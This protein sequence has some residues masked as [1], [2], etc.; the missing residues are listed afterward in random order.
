MT[1]PVGTISP[2]SAALA[3]AMQF[4]FL[5]DVQPVGTLFNPGGKGDAR[6]SATYAEATRLLGEAAAQPF[7]GAKRPSVVLGN[8]APVVDQELVDR[9]MTVAFAA[10]RES[11]SAAYK[12]GAQAAMLFMAGGALIV[13]DLYTPGSAERD[14]F[15]AGMDEG[16]EI[17]RSQ[18][19]K[20]AA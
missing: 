19:R 3:A 7:Q 8:I 2:L 18:L 13:P 17:W 16:R 4:K 20:E 9:L 15:I 11:R 6:T 1:V 5:L 12:E 10:P 14:A